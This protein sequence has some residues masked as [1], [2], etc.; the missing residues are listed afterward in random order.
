[1]AAEN[2][3]KDQRI[4]VMM[5]ID[6]VTRIDDWRRNQPS[7]P[8]RSEAIRRL[9]EMGLIG[10]ESSRSVSRKARAEAASRATRTIFT[11][12]AD[13]NVHPGKGRGRR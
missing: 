11:T 3:I 4:P 9:I 13:N 2:Q 6:E 12:I 1:M 5:A 10:S 7:L 8:S